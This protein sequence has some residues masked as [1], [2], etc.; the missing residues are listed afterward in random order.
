MNDLT[1]RQHCVA[2]FWARHYEDEG[3]YPALQ[4]YAS[5]MGVHRVTVFEHCRELVKRG[6]MERRVRQQP[7]YLLTKKAQR[8]F[9]NGVVSGASSSGK[10]RSD[11]PAEMRAVPPSD[12]E[13]HESREGRSS[14][15]AT[16]S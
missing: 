15:E 9:G 4:A 14:G 8:H 10:A 11:S 5:E 2:R 16:S 13:R 6:V 7:A 12:L 3:F 1:P